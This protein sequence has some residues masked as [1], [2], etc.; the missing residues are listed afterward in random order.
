MNFSTYEQ[1]LRD[2]ETLA[3]S[4]EF[5]LIHLISLDII[6]EGKPIHHY[7]RFDLFQSAAQHHKFALT[8]SHDSLGS[9]QDHQLEDA[10]KLMG[11]RILVTFAYKNIPDS[12]SRDFIGVI[13]E[14]AFST[15]P[16]SLG[17][18]VLVGSSPTTLLDAA[19]YM[20]S[21]GGK[22]PVS[23]KTV[24]DSV[25]NEGFEGKYQSR[26]EPGYTGDLSYSCQYRESHY[27]FLARTAEAYGEQFFYDGTTLHFGKLPIPE[28]AINLTLGRDVNQVSIRMKSR[29]VNRSLYGYSSINHE[30]LTT[31][32]TKISHRSSLAK[33]A[34]QLSEGIF[35]TPSL[36]IAPIKAA[37]HK[38]VEAAQKS[39]SGSIATDVFTT[40]GQT[41]VPFLYPGCIIEMNMLKPSSPESTYFTK[42]MIIQ[43]E[44][45]VDAL[46]NYIGLFE[47]IGADTGYLPKPT[48]ETP[49]MEQQMATITDN[50]DPYGRVQVRFDWQL[51][52]NTSEWIKVMSPDAGGSKQVGKN[53]G[54][55]AIPEIGDQVMVGFVHNHPD[56]PFVMGGLFHGKVGSGGGSGNS[57][58][59]LSSKSGHAVQLNDAEGITVK[60]KTGGN[61][62]MVDGKDKIDVTS[63][64]T[65]SITNGKASITLEEDKIT[66]YAD[67]IE[68]AKSGGESSKIEIKGID[69]TIFGESSMK[70]HSDMQAEINSQGNADLIAT[71]AITV[72][73]IIA[74]V[75]GKATTDIKG[76]VVNLN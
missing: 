51:N 48:F 39:A 18:L 29:H 66:L 20:Q 15:D 12:P 33:S 21:F 25:I 49:L 6:A 24:A 34:Y 16:H 54:F 69:T 7:K 13:T 38:D 47:A 43:I 76:G 56:R 14:I 65:V 68:L 73:G 35:K 41:T 32:E 19:P 22:Q 63:T 4:G 30:R 57:I 31:D 53:R 59:S 5:G 46:G 61:Y 74:T 10:Q 27:N 70:V 52:G 72:D 44:H 37:T 28:K 36:D 11:K 8:L 42:L 26:I 40:K 64:K 23:L 50:K 58:K 62:I 3:N 9:T 60:D 2:A 55:V 1:T 45:K 71:A 17:N 75:K 67:E